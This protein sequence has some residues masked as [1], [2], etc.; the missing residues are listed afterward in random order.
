MRQDHINKKNVEKACGTMT[1]MTG[2]AMPMYRP[3]MGEVRNTLC[4]KGAYT[5]NDM[6]MMVRKKDALQKA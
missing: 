3:L 2:T 5:S 6:M 4:M 1:G